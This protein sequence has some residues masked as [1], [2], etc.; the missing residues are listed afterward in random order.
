MEEG[1]EFEPPMNGDGSRISLFYLACEETITGAI[2]PTNMT[3]EDLKAI[4][5]NI[6][7]VKVSRKYIIQFA[8]S[9]RK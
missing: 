5:Q 4:A 2:K 6:V 3:E 1:V 9:K 8:G 7:D